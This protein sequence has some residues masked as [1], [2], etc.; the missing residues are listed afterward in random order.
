MVRLRRGLSAYAKHGVAEQLER[1]SVQ[2]S[3][4]TGFHD[5]VLAQMAESMGDGATARS[6]KRTLHA[7]QN[8][9]E[10]LAEINSE[11]DCQ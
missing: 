6:A 3:K 7:V 4:E 5:R 9:P 11:R 8:K 1:T 10:P 2:V